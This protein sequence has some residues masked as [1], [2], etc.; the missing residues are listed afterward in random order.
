MIEFSKKNTM[1]AQR[2]VKTFLLSTTLLLASSS[3]A[4][5][6]NFGQIAY[7]VELT[8]PSVSAG[9]IVSQAG[10]K[11]SLSTK[12]YDPGTYGVIV[13]DPA[14]SLNQITSTTKYI[15]ISGEVLVKVSKK[16]GDIKFGDLLTTSKDI[17]IGQKATKSG[18]VLGKALQDFPS[19][20]D[21]SEVGQIPVLL[22][23]N[24]NQVSAQSESLTQGGIDQVTKKVS[25]ALVSG[26]LSSLLKYI[27][28]LL[29]AI[30]SFFVGLYHFVRSNRTAVESIA[31]N[32]LAKRDIQRQLIVGTAGILIVSAIG[33]ALG[34]WILF[35]A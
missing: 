15:V 14:I 30:I 11:Y 24:Y 7:S 28:A 12:D 13:D 3:F 17:G 19:G 34:V 8:D 5:S 2:L 21:K 9:Q 1:T 33:M 35:F 31:R 23:I 16:N 20:S 6:Q 18:H 32:P 22:N 29:L 25:N 10:G 4:F 26:N 27:F